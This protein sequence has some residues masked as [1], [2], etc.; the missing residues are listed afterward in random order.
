MHCL[1]HTAN[2]LNVAVCRADNNQGGAAG[3]N[4]AVV[5]NNNN[6]SEFLSRSALRLLEH[7]HGLY[8]DL[9]QNGLVWSHNAKTMHHLLLLESLF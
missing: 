7:L 3:A 1:L 2:A 4:P 6:N 9:L 8:A 5:N